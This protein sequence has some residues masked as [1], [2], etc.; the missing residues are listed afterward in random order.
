[1]ELQFNV[2]EKEASDIINALANKPYN[3]VFQLIDK[4]QAQA[5]EQRKVAEDAVTAAKT[6]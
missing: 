2:T 4:L 5:V 6:E 3:T 1:M